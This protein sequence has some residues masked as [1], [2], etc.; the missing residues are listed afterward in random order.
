MFQGNLQLKFIKL[1]H[2]IVGLRSQNLE[3]YCCNFIRTSGTVIL[4][5]KGW[6]ICCRAA[7]KI[8]RLYSQNL[9][10]KR[11]LLLS[12][13]IHLLCVWSPLCASGG[14]QTSEPIRKL[15]CLDYWPCKAVPKSLPNPL[16]PC[17][18][19]VKHRKKNCRNNPI[20]WEK[21]VSFI[22]KGCIKVHW[23]NRDNS[24]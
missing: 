23:V 21:E 22:N 15:C 12:L 13:R 17:Q 4:C 6:A 24:V 16:H 3:C 20:M 7:Q 11:I 18:L 5:Y 8:E 19:C 2:V 9:K 10:L 1:N 14:S